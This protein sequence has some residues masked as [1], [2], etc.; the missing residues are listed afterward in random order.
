MSFLLRRLWTHYLFFESLETSDGSFLSNYKITGRHLVYFP[1]RFW[2]RT[3]NSQLVLW[4]VKNIRCFFT[5]QH[6]CTKGRRGGGGRGTSCTPRKCFEKLGH[7]NAIQHENRGPPRFLTTPSTPSKNLK[8]NEN[9]CLT[10]I[11]LLSVIYK[12]F[13]VRLWVWTHY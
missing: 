1:I 5:W 3:L 7:K 2:V 4:L 11:N 12:V 10:T 9:S 8:M 13:S 6:R